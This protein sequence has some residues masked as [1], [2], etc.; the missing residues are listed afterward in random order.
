MPSRDRVPFRVAPMLATLVDTPFHR[1]GWV[2]EEKYDGYRIVAYKEGANVTLCSRNAKDRTISFADV[3][4]DVRRLKPRTLVLDG[5]VVGFDQARVSRFQLLQQGESA[6]VYA[7]F[8]CL[9]CDGRD[10]RR[11]PLAR[12]REVLEHAIR[13]ARRTFPAR[14][15]A[16]N[17]ETA[18]ALAKRRDLEGIVAKDA[19]A[20]YIEGRSTKWLKIFP[21]RR[22]IP[23][24]GARLRF[25]QRQWARGKRNSPPGALEIS[26]R[27]GCGEWREPAR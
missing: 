24:G 17:G 9:Y 1:A 23:P 16:P 12:R 8:D 6:L 14:R 19:R 20:P 21:S 5:E 11:E 13:G 22:G 3:T 25:C 7:V 15:M 27:R 26:S 4:A 2:Y 18:Y 10:L